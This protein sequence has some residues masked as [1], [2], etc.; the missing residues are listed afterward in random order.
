MPSTQNVSY[1]E[2]SFPYWIQ[3]ARQ[4]AGKKYD[5]GAKDQV[6][7]ARNGLLPGAQPEV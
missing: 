1:P 4:R 6:P 7:S 5:I 2:Q 3:P